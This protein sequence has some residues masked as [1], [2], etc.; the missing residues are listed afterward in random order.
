MF[1]FRGVLDLWKSKFSFWKSKAF[2]EKIVWDFFHQVETH[3]PNPKQTKCSSL[4][5]AETSWHDHEWNVANKQKTIHF[6]SWRLTN[7]IYMQVYLG[8]VG[9][10]QFCGCIICELMSIHSI[11]SNPFRAQDLPMFKGNRL[12]FGKGTVDPSFVTESTAA[13]W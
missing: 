2:E 3:L 12:I 7:R 4:F 9:T 6:A 13:C 5:R 1:N 10:W 8:R 11:V